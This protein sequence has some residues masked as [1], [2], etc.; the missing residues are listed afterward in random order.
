MKFS[1]TLP[2][3]NG[4]IASF[5]I[6]EKFVVIEKNFFQIYKIYG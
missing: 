2:T 1:H 3:E 4:A 6:S 5:Q